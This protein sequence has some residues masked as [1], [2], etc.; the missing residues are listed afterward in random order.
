MQIT[1]RQR[2][3]LERAL[4]TMYAHCPRDEVE[5]KGLYCQAV[6]IVR[7]LPPDVRRLRRDFNQ[8]R[9]TPQADMPLQRKHQ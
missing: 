8:R 4:D 1:E 3:L 7:E 2:E 5:V 9:P 6:S